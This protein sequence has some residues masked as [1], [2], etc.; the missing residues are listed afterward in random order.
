MKFAV[1]FLA[2]ILVVATAQAQL[3]GME[4]QPADSG[5]VAPAAAV[6]TPVP[7]AAQVAPSAKPAE[8]SARPA[9]NSRR[10]RQG[11]AAPAPTPAR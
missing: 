6:A 4:L 3:P 1:S 9:G 10:M 7:A 11:G 5:Q 8:G 2:L